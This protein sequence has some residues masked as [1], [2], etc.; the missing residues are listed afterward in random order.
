MPLRQKVEEILQTETLDMQTQVT[1][2]QLN[3]IGQHFVVFTNLVGELTDIVQFLLIAA[4]FQTT[5]F[6]NDSVDEGGDTIDQ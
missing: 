1:L 6:M 2:T 3:P 4:I 5:G